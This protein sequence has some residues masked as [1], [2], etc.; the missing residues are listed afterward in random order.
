MERKYVRMMALS[1]RLSSGPPGKYGGGSAPWRQVCGSSA[2]AYRIMMIMLID[3]VDFD[4]QC[5]LLLFVLSPQL[6]L[7]SCNL[8]EPQNL[9]PKS[10]LARRQLR[11]GKG[12]QKNALVLEYSST[13]R[14]LHIFILLFGPASQEVKVGAASVGNE[15]RRHGQSFSYA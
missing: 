8:S 5:L 7:C 15:T 6:L 9:S 13:R 1:I 10:A 11:A 2:L 4:S 12:V 3:D 14:F